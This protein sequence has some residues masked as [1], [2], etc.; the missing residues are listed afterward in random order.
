MIVQTVLESDVNAIVAKA[1][2]F[3][4][5][6]GTNLSRLRKILMRRD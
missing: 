3:A 1:K 4:T 5:A 2:A 6:V